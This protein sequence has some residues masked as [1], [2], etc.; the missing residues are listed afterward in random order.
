MTLWLAS[1]ASYS[2]Q[3]GVFVGVAAV[4]MWLLRVRS[5]RATLRFWQT[6]FAGCVFWP[7]CQVA[8]FIGGSPLAASADMPAMLTSNA[9]WN[10]AAAGAAE[11]RASITELPTAAAVLMTVVF[12]AGAIVKLA[13]IAAGLLRLQSI[14]HGAQPALGLD[15]VMTSLRN[16]LGVIADIRYSDA[17]S[18]PAAT[19]LW[20]P[21]VLVPAR[22]AR[23]APPLQRA[24]LCHELLHVR[25]RDW[26]SS[27]IEELWCAL[28]WFNPAARTL[29][30]RLTLARETVVDE[31]TIA[32]TRDRRAYAAALLEFATTTT[33][34][35]GATPLIGRRQLGHRI[36]LIAQED[37]MS[38]L[39]LALRLTAAAGG[40]A[41]AALTTTPHLSIMAADQTSQTEKV[42]K[43]DDEGI[44]LPRIV[45]EV[46]PSYTAEALQARIQGTVHVT[47]VVLANGVVGRVVVVKSLDKEHGL[48]DQAVAAVR[49][50]K[51]VPG[52]KGGK[53]VPVEVTIELTFTLKK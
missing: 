47:A 31:A 30:S 8:A 12:A 46:K 49:K 29:T 43:G 16:E 1:L 28:F 18:S 53:A 25:R 35:P 6:I 21:L 15:A 20:Q 4:A 45:Y 7:I 3:V 33:R 32:H 41:L 34:L 9:V 51:F 50:W 2:V 14:R 38:R 27:L 42:Y 44:V 37:P 23:L 19:G 5:P 52:T 17:V 24:A 22:F 10:T 13:W 40:V 26:F 48:D 11:M 36:A 39:S